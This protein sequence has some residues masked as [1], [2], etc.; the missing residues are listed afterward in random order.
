[1]VNVGSTAFVARIG[2][3]TLAEAQTFC[4]AENMV[5]YTPSN[6]NIH[7]VIY[8][9]VAAYGVT[10]FWTNAKHDFDQEKMVWM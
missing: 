10:T 9:K 5:L 1:M 8:E 4:A 6:E 2:P 7:R 3:S